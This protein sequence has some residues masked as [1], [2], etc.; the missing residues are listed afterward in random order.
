MKALI[1]GILAFSAA[2]AVP[3]TGRTQDYP[4][5]T[6]TIVVPYSAGGGVDLVARLVADQLSKSLD[7]AVVVE[8]RPGANGN[9]GAAYVAR[10]KPDGYTLLY[11]APGPL[12]LNKLLYAELKYDPDAFV[13]ISQAVTSP[14]VLVVHPKLGISKV[15]ELIAYAKANPDRL[16]YASSG[17]G[18]TP[19]LSAELF[20]S[21]A[22]VKMVHIPY[23]GTAPL[24]TDLLGGQ[25]DVA[26]SGLS[27]V[28]EYVN[29]RKLRALAVGSVKRNSALPNVPALTEVLPGFVSETWSAL[30]APPGTPKAIAQR[31]HMA[32]SQSFKQ[33]ETVKRTLAASHND[34]VVN[35]PEE[36]AAHIKDEREHW[37]KVIRE[38]G[39]KPM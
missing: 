3:N 1:V 27:N 25:V 9:I 30:V 15:E 38:I 11:S 29:S 39:L 10:S 36:L 19:H 7:A 5:Q 23:K 20:K 28:L 13:P 14:N 33:S 16:S 24:I 34:V 31:L 2:L 18:G 17:N 37:G 12:A 35:T 22:G 4:S 6:V 32:L 21:L 8:N 26:F